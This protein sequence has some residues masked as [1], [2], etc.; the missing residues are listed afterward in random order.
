MKTIITFCVISLL[1]VNIDVCASTSMKR[2]WSP[3]RENANANK[4]SVIER[5]DLQKSSIELGSDK[6]N[7]GKKDK[8]GL[9]QEEIDRLAGILKDLPDIEG[10]YFVNGELS[11]T[12][13][14]Y[15]MDDLLQRCYSK[16]ESDILGRL[17]KLDQSALENYCNI[18]DKLIKA[19]EQIGKKNYIRCI[20]S[21]LSYVQYLI[22]ESPW[23]IVDDE[24]YQANQKKAIEF[25]SACRDILS[26][27]AYILQ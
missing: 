4:L 11:Y 18:C 5:D 27:Y 23:E 25:F 2:E 21:S 26:K 22:V 16:C 10:K 7:Q 12:D 17:S 3:S 20:K 14:C 8:D 24:Y 15:F 13:E 1:G 9:Y 19:F 6:T